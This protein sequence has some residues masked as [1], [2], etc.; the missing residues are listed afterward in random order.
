[1]SWLLTEMSKAYHNNDTILDLEGRML[2]LSEILKN[3]IQNYWKEQ[4]FNCSSDELEITI[5]KSSGQY[6]VPVP[7]IL[8]PRM[9]EE[10]FKNKYFE[11]VLNG[12]GTIVDIGIVERVEN[13]K[14]P[15]GQIVLNTNPRK[16]EFEY[17]GI[18]DITARPSKVSGN[19]FDLPIGTYKVRISKEK[20]EP[21]DTTIIIATGKTTQLNLTL[22]AN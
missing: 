8:K 17:T 13:Q 3:K 22:K 20:Y 1:M 14:N 21:I 5:Q 16:V 10:I 11:I 18:D 19:I 6:I 2:G 7:V 9:G 4:I 15:I 12:S